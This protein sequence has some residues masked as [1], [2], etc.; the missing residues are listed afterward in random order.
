MFNTPGALLK[1]QWA[2]LSTYSGSRRLSMF[3]LILL[4][5]LDIYVL[6][7]LFNGMHEAA[8]TIAY[9]ELAISE[10]CQ[11]MMEGYQ[12]LNA[13]EKADR[14]KRFVVLETNEYDWIRSS[15][16]F[17]ETEKLAVCGQLRD[18]LNSYAGNAPLGNLFRDFD[19]RREKIS[20]IRTEIRELK[21]SYDSALLE[22][23]AGQ[24]REDSILPAEATRTKSIIARKMSD[25]ADL[26]K[27]QAEVRNAIENHP[28]IQ[29]YS[30]FIDELPYVAEFAKAR[31]E[32]AHLSFW[33]PIKVFAVE[34]SFLLPLLLLAIVWNLRALKVQSNTQTLIS[35]HLILVCAIPVFVR[36]VYFVYELLPHRLLASLIASLQALNL[37]FLWNYVAIIGGIGIGLAVIVIAQ[38]TFFSPAR[39]RSA[40]LRKTLCRECGEKL[41]SADQAWCEFCGTDQMGVCTHCGEPHRLLAYHCDHCGSV[42]GTN[43]SS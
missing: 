16:G 21:S 1:K 35:S 2:R 6:G 14:L 12:K 20:S 25:L 40:R 5:G 37:G 24:K 34:V 7:L 30:D 27:K 15:A 11:S 26:E 8:R 43:A 41:R 4:F 13:A 17:A 23:I 9:P 29:D 10:G 32:Y 28:L 42:L 19:Q 3:S 38:R 39:Q 36:V 18:K 31:A 22:K 33:Y